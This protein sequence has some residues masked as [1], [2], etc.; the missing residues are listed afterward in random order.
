MGLRQ[1]C[2]VLTAALVI[3]PVLS[4]PALAAKSLPGA[5]AATAGDVALDLTA[6]T[7]AV[8]RA[9]QTVTISGT[10][11]NPG[12]TTLHK[13]VVRVVAE[14]S[15][16]ARDEVLAWVKATGPALGTQLASTTLP[17]DLGPG[18]TAPFQ[19]KIPDLASQ[20]P[21][22]YG[23]LPISIESGT[24]SVRTFAGYQVIKQYQPMSI[25]WAVPMTLDPDAE[26]F[27]PDGANRELAWTQAV[28]P[29]SRLSRILDATAEAP[30]TWAVDPTLTPSL[31]PGSVDTSPATSQEHLL[32]AA[33]EGRIRDGASRHTPW[34]LPDTDADIAALVDAGGGQSLAASLVSRAAPVAQALGGRADVAWPSD[35]RT[36]SSTEGALSR[37][38]HATG[39]AGEVTSAS[40]RAVGPSGGT[41]AAAQRSTSGVPLLAY[42]AGLSALLARTTAGDEGVLSTQQFVA[43]SAALLNELPGTQGRSVFVVAP[44][45]YDP[46]PTAART[47]F[48]ATASI[49][50]LTTTTTDAELSAARTAAPT[51][52]APVTLSAQ[53]S[54]A[55]PPVL[56]SARLVGLEQTLDT[57]H[58]ISQVREDGATFARTWARAT[59]QLASTRWRS[60][61]PGWSTV[62]RRILAATRQTTTAV[63]VLA[64]T[65]NFLAD[66]GRL[67]ITITNG[68]DVPVR[69]IKVTVDASN[70]RLRIDSQPPVLR[71]GAGSRATV[72]VGVTALAAGIVPLRTTLTTPD[73][74]VIGQGADVEVR[75]TPTGS[76]VYW[77][78]GGLAGVVLLLGI[79][80]SFTRRP[81][82]RPAADLPGRAKT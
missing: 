44:R 41:P 52:G 26:L 56:T 29:Q 5:P 15:T 62:N 73:G 45:T 67:Q 9:G 61:P 82:S 13:P 28:G 74:T 35:P 43:E 69:N 58:G 36:T 10:V 51:E 65:I 76:W 68:L 14:R 66:S 8:A 16:L 17:T 63:K 79:I 55:A 1:V 25:A 54:T 30:V 4:G 11:R 57:V 37:L 40:Q 70:P 24:A 64:G 81:A 6:L 23:A 53:P 12:S 2:R 48:A 21:A 80:R 60:A 39:L 71:I 50:W 32:R 22:M 46:D 3:L 7:P 31:L 49:P 78:L 47:F 59:E 38:F 42:D 20:G 77:A 33:L 34:V 72:N 75:V 27:G 18:A 19:V